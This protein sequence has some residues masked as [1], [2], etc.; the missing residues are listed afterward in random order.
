MSRLVTLAARREMFASAS[1]VVWR[2]LVTIDHPQL[3]APIRVVNDVVAA[4]PEGNRT[5]ASRGATFVCYPFDIDLPGDDA[6]SVART[7]IQIDNVDREIID[8]LR[9]ISTPCAVTLEVVTAQ[10]PDDVQAG[11][12]ELSLVAAEYDALTISGDLTVEDWL[13]AP[14]PADRY[15]PNDYPALF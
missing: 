11:P 14:F 12:F 1:G 4:D 6:E 5:V 2:L 10:E 7:T 13:S 3:A 9:A 15:S 8:N